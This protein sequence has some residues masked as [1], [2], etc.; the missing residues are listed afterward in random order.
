MKI[1]IGFKEQSLKNW[2]K[3]LCTIDCGGCSFESCSVM[4]VTVKI[5][6][7]NMTTFSAMN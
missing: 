1:C 5:V 4:S 3:E 7:K 6:V 2:G